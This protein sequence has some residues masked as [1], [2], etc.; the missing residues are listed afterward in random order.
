MLLSWDRRSQDDFP[1]V[2]M[3]SESMFMDSVDRKLCSNIIHKYSI[4]LDI[5]MGIGDGESPCKETQEN[6][7]DHHLTTSSNIDTYIKKAL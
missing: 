3:A 4:W 6:K 1:V 2:R 5:Y 7:G